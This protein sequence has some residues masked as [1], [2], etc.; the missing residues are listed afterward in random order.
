MRVG[1]LVMIDAL[2][3]KGIWNRPAIAANPDV[4]IDKLRALEHQMNAALDADFGGSRQGAIDNPA[5]LL[6]QCSL[7]FLSDT[8]VL[9]V[10]A[11]T[12]EQLQSDIMEAPQWDLAVAA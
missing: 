2:G 6:G 1:A 8:I 7:I 12:R 4:V 11:K 5:N 10:A 9:G 3:F